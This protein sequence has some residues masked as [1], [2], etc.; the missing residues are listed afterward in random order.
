MALTLR[1]RRCCCMPVCSPEKEYVLKL[2]KTTAV[3]HMPN[4]HVKYD[5]QIC[6]LIR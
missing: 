3:V 6:T 1:K 5:I 2:T 4:A